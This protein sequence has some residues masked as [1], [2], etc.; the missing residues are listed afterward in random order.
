MTQEIHENVSQFYQR[1]EDLHS[2]V[3][4]TMHSTESNQEVLNG[5][6]LMVNGI[7][8][9][10]FV[11]HTHPQISQMLRYREFKNINSAFTA[12][13][14]EEKA[15]RLTY[16]EKSHQC[17]ICDRTN[18]TTN[19]CYRNK[20]NPSIRSHSNS[21]AEC[22]NCNMRCNRNALFCSYLMQH[23]MFILTLLT[24]DQ[25]EYSITIWAK[26]KSLIQD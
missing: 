15:L 13:I 6:L 26:Q 25:V 20:A 1:L 11:H 19:N 2:K 17:R 9:N 7:T 16:N 14:A 23:P 12:A 5:R 18:H 8:L 24:T 3:L 22:T 21:S 10:R 4:G